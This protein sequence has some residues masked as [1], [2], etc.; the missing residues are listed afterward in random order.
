MKY[1]SRDNV[2]PG[3]QLEVDCLKAFTIFLMLIVHA[4]ENCA[5][6]LDNVI[7]QA[8][9]LMEALTGAATFMICMGLGMR[10]SRSQSPG[11]YLRRGFELLT[12]GQLLN[13]L[14]DSLPTLIGYWITGE[15]KYIANVLV[16][17]TDILTFAGFAFILMALLV[18][19]K[20]S[21]GVILGIGFGMNAAA[22]ALRG[23]FHTTG[24]Y[25]LDQLLGFFVVTDAEAYF[26]LFS[27]FVF[28]AFGYALGGVYR[29]IQDKDGLSARVLQIGLPVAAL[30]YALRLT[31]PLPL[32]P[33]FLSVE[34]YILNPLT[35]ALVNCL[36]T[37]CMLA[38]F[39]KLLKRSGGRCPALVTHLSRHINSYYCTS[40]VLYT[41]LGTLM[42][43][44]WGSR[45][46]G[47]VLPFLYG[48]L[49]MAICHAVIDWNESRLHFTIANL[50]GRRRTIVYAAIWLATLLIC[51]YAYP[52]IEVFATIWNDY[53]GV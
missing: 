28:V 20:A 18:R 46:P 53:L 14:R 5:D 6:S 52:R 21:P 3:R 36:M 34:Q 19:S 39:H 44:L 42:V 35:D 1:F 38:L 29:R 13:I 33:E 47:A 16:V 12:V 11:G 51:V 15:Q 2:N 32:L 41:P 7:F 45:M 25:A 22:L 24:N 48:L 9:H 26:P 30:Y 23:G 8:F 10:Y 43:L 27:Y 50:K 49:V 37:L 4:Y 31:V 17:Q 40:F